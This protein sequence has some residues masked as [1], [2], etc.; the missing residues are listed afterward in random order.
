MEK[1]YR[2]EEVREVLE[3]YLPVDLVERVIGYIGWDKKLPVNVMQ[4]VFY[5][6]STPCF[7]HRY[8]V[9]R[10]GL[11][12]TKGGVLV[13]NVCF[14]CYSPTQLAFAYKNDRYCDRSVLFRDNSKSS[15]TCFSC[16]LSLRLFLR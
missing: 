14:N 7:Y 4:S 12:K 10:P 16:I 11:P 3:V 15:T 13:R 5:L 8:L 9:S 2:D 6:S 1:Y